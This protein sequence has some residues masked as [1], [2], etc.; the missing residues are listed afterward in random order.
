MLP[1]TDKPPATITVYRSPGPPDQ[2]TMGKMTFGGENPLCTLE[3]AKVNPVNAGHPAI[4]AGTYA[5]IVTMSPH[6]HYASPELQKVPGREN[7]RI[8]ILNTAD[9]TLGCIGVGEYI[10][11]D[12]H[13]LVN[14]K[15]A[16]DAMM[17]W[18]GTLDTT[19]QVVVMDA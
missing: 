8:H 1:S 6:M 16:F 11:K 4:G 19:L 3:P 10:G 15:L 7:I 18:L 13:S 2:P 12:G 9:Q 5:A 14:S 17:K